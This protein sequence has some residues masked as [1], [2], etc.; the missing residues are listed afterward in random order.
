MTDRIKVKINHHPVNYRCIELFGGIFVCFFL[1]FAAGASHSIGLMIASY[2]SLFAIFG[3]GE[4]FSAINGYLSVYDGAI[5][6]R[7]IKYKSSIPL[8]DIAEISYGV[9]TEYA[10]RMST[11]RI[12]LNIKTIDGEEHS[13]NDK[14][15]EEELASSLDP[16][17][18]CNVPVI[19][20]YRFLAEKLP[21]KA[22]G[23]VKIEN[24]MEIL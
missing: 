5:H 9:Y 23:Y 13:F 7:Y 1:M 11:K 24:N 15:N 20:M 19:L 3:L 21:D 22:K 17:S 12:A 14:I 8:I 4:F 6:F 10:G 18:R 2:I 16:N